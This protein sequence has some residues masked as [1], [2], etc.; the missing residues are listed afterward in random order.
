[1][2]DYALGWSDAAL[3]AYLT[4]PSETQQFVDTRI[5]QLLDAPDGPGS[6]YDTIF[7][8]WTTTAAAGTVLLVYVFRVGRP[9]LVILR[10][11]PI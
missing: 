6:S 8:R 3:D 1:M 2:A 7:D 5:A 10:L 11:I 4:L 9:R